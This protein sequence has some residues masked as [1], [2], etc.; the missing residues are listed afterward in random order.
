MIVGKTKDGSLQQYEEE[1]GGAE[2]M[3]WSLMGE[4]GLR[5]KG[6]YG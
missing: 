3:W 2:K 4:G 5:L 1:E 6:S